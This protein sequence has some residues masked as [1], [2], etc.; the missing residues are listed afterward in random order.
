M[1][2][3]CQC[4]HSDITSLKE[5]KRKQEKEESQHSSQPHN[6]IKRVPKG[7]SNLSK[8]TSKSVTTICTMAKF[9]VFAILFS[10]TT[11]IPIT[12]HLTTYINPKIHRRNPRFLNLLIRQFII[13]WVVKIAPLILVQER[14]KK[15]ISN[16][17]FLFEVHLQGVSKMD[18]LFIR[19]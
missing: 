17:T 6:K 13:L 2:W 12:W 4:I 1:T 8:L 5:M 15:A 10:N 3:V 19:E 9:L 16:R 7:T 18:F 11:T 14:I